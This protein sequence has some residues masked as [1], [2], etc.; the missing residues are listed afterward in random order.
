MTVQVLPLDI[1]TENSENSD[2]SAYKSENA[3]ITPENAVEKASKK[4]GRPAGAV[5]AQKRKT[6]VRQKKEK[7]RARSPEPI[8]ETIIETKTV[9]KRQKKEK[10]EIKPPK[11]PKTSPII[12]KTT[13]NYGAEPQPPQPLMTPHQYLRELQHIH[14]TAQENHWANI[15]GPMFH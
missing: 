6:P 1:S 5:D 13:P 14:R 7:A 15:I 4:R 8:I 3:P 2:I 10:A 9:P 11:T 12:A